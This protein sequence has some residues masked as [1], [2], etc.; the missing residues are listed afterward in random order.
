MFKEVNVQKSS[1]NFKENQHKY[2]LVTKY[3]FTCF[4]G[5]DPYFSI[6]ASLKGTDGCHAGG[7]L[8]DEI[9]KHDPGLEPLIKWHLVS[10]VKG[11]M[12]YIANALFWWER[13]LMTEPEY[14]GDIT[15]IGE[16]ALEYF[17]STVVYD[18]TT[19]D[20]ISF[21]ERNTISIDVLRKW[22]EDRFNE[23]MESFYKD[24]LKFQVIG[25][26]KIK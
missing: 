19:I 18:S 25:I 5:Q 22:L 21:H 6:T 14:K 20:T 24:L 13:S 9:R 3:G 4:D 11:P 26:R 10:L 17:K 16:K 2:R 1:V 7:C 15:A 8:H 12:H 23:M